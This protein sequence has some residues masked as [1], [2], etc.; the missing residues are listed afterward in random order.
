MVC[1]T[2]GYDEY[3]IIKSKGKKKR[4]LLVKCAECGQIYHEI[5]SEEA[6]E[7]NV[8]VII[9]EYETS[10]KTNVKLYSDEYLENGTLLYIDDMDVEV[11]SIENSEGNRVYECPVVDIKTIWA[12]SL[13]SLARIGLSID[14]HGTVLSHKIEVERDFVFEIGDIGVVDGN[15]F[16]IYAFKTLERNMRKGYAY[17]KVIKRIYGRLL[18]RNDKSK[19][20]YDLSEYVIKTTIKEKDYN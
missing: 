3:E 6:H 5:V 7:V 1:P 13:D 10:W 4:D 11:T 18:P 20:K 8:R 2:C 19:I 16:K 9:S 15:K 17:A 14:N 12:K